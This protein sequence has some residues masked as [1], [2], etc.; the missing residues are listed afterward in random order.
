ML[1]TLGGWACVALVLALSSGCR[2][3]TVQATY[4]PQGQDQA[5][6]ID[7]RFHS[8]SEVVELLIDNQEVL[9]TWAA[10]WS[11]VKKSAEYKGH[12]VDMTLTRSRRAVRCLVTVD[13]EVAGSWDF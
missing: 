3:T 9:R 1:R 7:V 13:N 4:R 2:K 10:R 5:M 11:T 12:K 8:A 6:Q